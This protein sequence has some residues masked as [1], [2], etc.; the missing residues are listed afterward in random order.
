ML[1]RD[2]EYLGVLERAQAAHLAAGE[3]PPIVLL[4]GP[5][6]SAEHWLRVLPDL[7][8]THRVVAPDLPGHGRSGGG[9]GLDADRVLAWLGEL[10]ER[11]CASPPALVGH[12]LGGAIAARAAAAGTP[13][14]TSL[15]LVDALGLIPFSPAAELGAALAAFM[16]EPRADAF[17]RW[18]REAGEGLRAFSTGGSYI[19]FQTADE[20]EERIRASY[21]ANFDRVL[22]VK[23]RVDPD[24]VFRSNRN[25]RRPLRTAVPA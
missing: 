1:A 7:A 11:T 13:P 25:V 17:R 18:I 24:N 10:V 19:D 20:G 22:A 23:E 4:H 5:G 3:G 6:G 15:V 14:L 9:E 12:A 2:D 21:G 16:A 8:R